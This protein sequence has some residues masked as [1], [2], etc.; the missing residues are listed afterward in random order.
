MAQ[1]KLAFQHMCDSY[2]GSP[3]AMKG[4]FLETVQGGVIKPKMRQRLADWMLEV[5]IYSSEYTVSCVCVA[6]F[7]AAPM[8]R[9]EAKFGTFFIQN[10]HPIAQ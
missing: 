5:S 8:G 1:A 3:P 6:L 4:D 7:V 9:R 2:E 10:C